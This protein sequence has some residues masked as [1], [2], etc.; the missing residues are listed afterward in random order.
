MSFVHLGFSDTMES[1]YWRD[2]GLFR[3]LFVWLGYG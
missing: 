3:E 1:L 2:E